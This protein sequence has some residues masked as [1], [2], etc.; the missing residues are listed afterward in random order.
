MRPFI[1]TIEEVF[2]FL[3]QARDEEIEKVSSLIASKSHLGQSLLFDV[4][5]NVSIP[6][7]SNQHE[8]VLHTLIFPPKELTIN[9]WGL[10]YKT[11]KFSSRL[12]EV[13]KK[14]NIVLVKREFKKFVNRFGHESE[15]RVYTP[16][17]D[18]NV[19]IQIY[20]EMKS[21]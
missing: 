19:Y 5:E 12:G 2:R 17:H 11:N 10:V 18:Q 21:K 14:L 7:P 15:Y 3:S 9:Y 16:I 13:E 4:R 20:N 6:S 1:P 8:L